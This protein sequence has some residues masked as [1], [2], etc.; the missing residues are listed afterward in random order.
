MGI[1]SCSVNYRVEEARK[2][3]VALSLMAVI[4]A[5]LG[6]GAYSFVDSGTHDL[7]FRNYFHYSAVSGWMLV[8]GMAAVILFL[9]LIQTVYA[10]IRIRMLRRSDGESGRSPAQRPGLPI[11]R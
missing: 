8:A 7:A 9:F 10:S 5:V 3:K 4:L 1:L 2:H 11:S 6:V